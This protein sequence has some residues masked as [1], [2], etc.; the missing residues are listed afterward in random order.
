MNRS[1]Q[2]KWLAEDEED[3]HVPLT[4]AFGKEGSERGMTIEKGQRNL[5]QL[6]QG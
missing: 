4:C 2:R 1:K 6:Y 5:L 3:H